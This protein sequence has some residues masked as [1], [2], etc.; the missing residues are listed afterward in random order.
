MRGLLPTE[1]ER[2]TLKRRD[3]Q[4][5]SLAGLVLNSAKSAEVRIV[6]FEI[7]HGGSEI[8]FID[9]HRAPVGIE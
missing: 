6:K 5:M 4:V 7:G 9:E 8:S 3:N 2:R 1:E